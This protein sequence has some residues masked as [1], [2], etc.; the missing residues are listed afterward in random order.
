MSAVNDFDTTQ[1]VLLDASWEKVSAPTETDIDGKS[2][3]VLHGPAGF[4]ES[5]AFLKLTPISLKAWSNLTPKNQF[6][7]FHGQVTSSSQKPKVKMQTA[8]IRSVCLLSWPK[9]WCWWVMTW[10]VIWLTW[11]PP[12]G[13]QVQFVSCILHQRFFFRDSPVLAI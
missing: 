2:K 3:A 4:P 12:L 5:L 8:R 11:S 10:D 13:L 6:S 7:S 1:M 9:R